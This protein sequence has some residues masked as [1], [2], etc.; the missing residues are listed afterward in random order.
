MRGTTDGLETSGQTTCFSLPAAELG[1][2]T[3]VDVTCTPRPGSG[4]DAPSALA[5]QPAQAVLALSTVATEGV[6]VASARRLAARGRVFAN[7]RLTVPGGATPATLDSSGPN[8]AVR[9]G[10]CTAAAG[11]N[12]TPACVTGTV[13]AAPG[14]PAPTAYPAVVRTLPACTAQARV[15]AITP[16]TYLSGAA[17]QTALNCAST[18][19]VIWFQPGT[20]YFDFRDA[21]TAAR[22]LDVPTTAGTTVVGGTPLNWTP[23]TTLP[24]AVPVPTAAQPTRSACDPGLPGVQFVFAADSRLYV[25]SGADIQLCAEETGAAAQHVVLRGLTSQS[26]ALPAAAPSTGGAIL[27]ANSG[28]GTAWTNP[29][30]GD[31]VDGTSASVA[32][33][34]N[35]TSRALRV[36]RFPAG[37]VPPEATSLSVTVSVTG[38]LNGTSAATESVR[39]TDGTTTL[40]TTTLRTCPVAG[41]TDGALRTDSVTISAPGLT[42]AIV[43]LMYVE[44]LVASPDVVGSTTALVDGVTV[45]VDFSAPMRPTSGTSVATPYVSGSAATTAILRTAGAFPATVVALHGTVDAP[46]AAVDLGVTLVPY[47]VVDRGL[48]VRHLHSAMSPAA[49]YTGPLVSVPDLVQVPRRVLME[50]KDTSSVVLARADVTY[51]N[52]AGPAATT[53]GTIPTVNE[54]TAG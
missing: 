36:G 1:N 6:T 49:G 40:G 46:L 2:A 48:V 43:N 39:L 8:S 22:E 16:G 50:A 19:R 20:Y 17:L 38:R 47:T 31:V 52:V 33:A 44:V 7:S 27:G 15:V 4:G 11:A 18:T 37:L 54:W 3:R 14:W 9:A 35:T 12:V 42:P 13:P 30:E 32:V 29:A 21:T 51:G 10:D 25:P 41:C 5:S 28:T 45:S 26:P 53:N 24:A 23:N 34:R